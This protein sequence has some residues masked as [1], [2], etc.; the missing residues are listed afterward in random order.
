MAIENVQQLHDLLEEDSR[1]TVSELCFRLLV[2]D[3]ARTSMYKIVHNI[4]SFCKLTSCWVPCLRTEDRKKSRMD[5]ALEFLKV[6]ERER[7][8]LIGCMVAGDETWVHLSTPESKQQSMALCEQGEPASKKAK[9]G[10]SAN[11]IMVTVFWDAK[12][13]L[14]IEYHSKGRN[15]NQQLYQVT[16]KKLRAVIHRL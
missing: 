16:L 12:G 1:M 5:V 9:V 14:L 7:S 2:A 15:V 6:Y 10:R 3:C 4:L 8:S 11:K 13:V